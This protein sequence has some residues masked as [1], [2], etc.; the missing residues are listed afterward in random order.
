M[1]AKSGVLEVFAGIITGW[2]LLVVPSTSLLRCHLDLCML[3]ILQVVLGK[4][5]T[6]RSIW[7]VLFVAG[8][9]IN[10]LLFMNSDLNIAIVGLT[11]SSIGFIG[12]IA[13]L[14]FQ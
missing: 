7:D 11:V 8:C 9:W 12:R 13:P 3:G 4:I 10:P 1:L 5:D 6:R 14:L 2:M